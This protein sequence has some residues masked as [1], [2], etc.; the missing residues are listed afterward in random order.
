[1][2]HY[3]LDQLMIFRQLAAKIPDETACVIIRMGKVPYMDQSGLYAVEDLVNDMR[4]QGKSV[5]LVNLKK[6]PR[7]MMERIDIIPDLIEEEHIFDKFKDCLKWVV[8]NIEDTHPPRT[9]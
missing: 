8:A 7:Y 4:A 2:D 6:Q 5:L 3:S 1:M 9:A